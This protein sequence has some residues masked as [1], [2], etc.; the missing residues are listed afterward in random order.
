MEEL[1]WLLNVFGSLGLFL[2][3]M[4]IMTSGLKDLA[5]DSIRKNLMYYTRSPLTGALTG[6]V[7]TAILQ[8]S[9]AVTVTTVG[10]VAA[11]LMTFSHSLGVIFGANIGTTLTGWLVLLFGFKI[12]L[13]LAALPLVFIGAVLKLFSSQKWAAFGFAVAGFGLL[14]VGIASLQENMIVM[15]EWFDFST[16][17]M[18]SILQLLLVVLFGA[19]FTLITQSSSAGVAATLTAL[20]SDAIDFPQAAA[21]VVGMDIGTTVTAALATTGASLSAR[22]TGF[23]HVIY[24][25]LTGVTAILLIFPYISAWQSVF[26]SNIRESGEVALIAFHSLFNVLGVAIALPFTNQF[27]T[28]IIKLFPE[29]KS[30]LHRQLD[31]SILQH[32]EEA[33]NISQKILWQ[34]QLKLV[35]LLCDLLANNTNSTETLERT[36]KELDFIS[37]FI[38][39]ISLR[40]SP[41]AHRK[42]LMHLIH[43]LDHLQRLQERLED[44]NQHAGA[45]RNNP[46]LQSIEKLINEGT[47]YVL[48]ADIPGNLQSLRKFVNKLESQISGE[49]P[50]IRERLLYQIV[51]EQLDIPTSSM[52][53]EALR[54]YEHVSQ[55]L[56]RITG[57]YIA[58]IEMTGK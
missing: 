52:Q 26:G 20:Y 11:G 57:H 51:N 25:L 21:L 14:F 7:C 47:N 24:N 29:K 28:L 13:G 49:A 31:T 38:D 32:A 5:G 6:T 40:K 45:L 2:L 44:Y 56:S 46:N 42:R 48:H 34:Y 54:W 30:E 43:M 50:A 22:R 33:L 17:P 16:L 23:S 35:T 36:G 18:N 4:I 8:S 19:T 27:T 15:R 58:A 3:G 39:D 55:H 41:E 37:H 53:L 1:G 10:F 12:K 9:S